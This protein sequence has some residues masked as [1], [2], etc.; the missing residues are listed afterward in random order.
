M[1]S[2]LATLKDVVLC[3]LVFVLCL[4]VPGFFH[5]PGWT[6]WLCVLPGLLVLD[7]RLGNPPAS[8][9]A[10]VQFVVGFG[11]CLW[12]WRV[13]FSP[14][15]MWICILLFALCIPEITRRSTRRER[16]TSTPAT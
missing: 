3:T 10:R 9:R 15:R 11:V 5:W 1:Q 6:Y 16:E 12:L 8:W 2:L 14:D 13:Y 4:S 7:R